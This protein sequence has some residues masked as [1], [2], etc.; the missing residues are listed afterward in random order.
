MVVIWPVTFNELTANFVPLSVGNPH[1]DGQDDLNGEIVPDQ[2]PF[3]ICGG[4]SVVLGQFL[5][6]HDPALSRLTGMYICVYMCSG[7]GPLLT[8]SRM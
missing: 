6:V 8:L 7:L 3:T 5:P 2:S 1:Q 4:E